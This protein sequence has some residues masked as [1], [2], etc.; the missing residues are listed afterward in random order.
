MD[1]IK[2]I[3]KFVDNNKKDHFNI[4][5]KQYEN[6]LKYHKFIKTVEEFSL[7]TLKGSMK[8][9]NKYDKK[10]R[11]GGLLIKIYKRNEDWYAIIKQTEKKYYVSFKSN[12][13]FYCPNIGE[14]HDKE[15]K[16]SL[17]YFISEVEEGKYNII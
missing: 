4:I 10:L 14:I 17:K 9:I 2:E 1:R 7:L 8:Y 16:D 15:L 3:E 12:Y 11:Y 13:I 5:L 6:E